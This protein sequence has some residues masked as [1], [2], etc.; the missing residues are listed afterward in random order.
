MA[1]VSTAPPSIWG[2]HDMDPATGAPSGCGLKGWY[3]VVQPLD[4][5]AANG[6]KVDYAAGRP[7]GEH[8]HYKV[9]TAQRLD[10][11][12]VI[13]EWRRLRLRHK[14]AYEIDDDCWSITKENWA[15]YNT[16]RRTTVLDIMTHAAESADLI[17]VSTQSLAQVIRDRTG[18]GKIRVCP[19]AVPDEL[20]TMMRARSAPATVT[21]GWA[22]GSS[23]AMDLAMIGVPVHDLIMAEPTAELHIFGCDFRPTFGLP[24]SRCRYT[25]WTPVNASLDY[26]KAI[27]FDIALAPLTGTLFDQSKSSIKILESMALGIPA[28]ASDTGPYHDVIVDGVN[29][30]LIRRRKD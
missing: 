7:P 5:L 28:V 11:P 8:E 23:H 13:P 3:R 2:I 16:Y 30:Y 19:N 10:K 29:G 22:G 4:A 9:L 20:L 21:I 15:A 6:W 12:E 1:L 25:P 26:Y 17:T 18:H 27:D 24:K 14:L